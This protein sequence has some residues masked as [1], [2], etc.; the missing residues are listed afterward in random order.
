MGKRVLVFIL[1]FLSSLITA[2]SN[3]AS[4]GDNKGM[5]SDFN[6]SLKYSTYGKQVIDTFNDIVIKDLVLVGTV[7]AEIAFTDVEMK[8]IYNKMIAIDIMGELD[9]EKE[10]ECGSEPESISNWTIQMN[11]ETKSYSYKSYCNYPEDVLNLIKLED[12]IHNLMANKE[13]YKKL[14]ESNGGYE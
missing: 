9:L 2:C 5:P 8:E 14:P 12:F 13:E 6:F 3:E 10:K 1:I 7:E 4:S 11:G